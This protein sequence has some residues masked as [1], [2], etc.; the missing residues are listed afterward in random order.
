MFIFFENKIEENC[1]DFKMPNL[2]SGRKRVV[3]R[4]LTFVLGGKITDFFFVGLKK[5]FNTSSHERIMESLNILKPETK[6]MS[7]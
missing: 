5:L 2:G 4:N 6:I 1:K 7:V 3:K